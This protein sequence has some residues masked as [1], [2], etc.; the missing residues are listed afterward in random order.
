[1]RAARGA[2]LENDV[3]SS[4]VRGRSS[5]GVLN[6]RQ[7]AVPHWETLVGVLADSLRVSEDWLFASS[8]KVPPNH[9][10]TQL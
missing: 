1:M 4:G 5:P 7:A 10:S 8:A 3:Q 9:P 2:G 6:H